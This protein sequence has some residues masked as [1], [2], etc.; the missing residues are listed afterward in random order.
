MWCG[1][2]RMFKL[3]NQYP[4]LFE[5]VT[6]R[7]RGRARAPSGTKRKKP[8]DTCAQS[9]ATVP[10]PRHPSSSHGDTVRACVQMA[11]AQSTAPQTSPKPHGR[12]VTSNDITE[13]LIGREAEVF[14]SIFAHSLH[15]I[16]C[17][18]R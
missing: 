14:D 17:L 5:I 9:R 13:A 12:L 7:E 2:L 15:I 10:H 8:D 4:T 3:M 11:I 6:E 1:S 18:H 16:G